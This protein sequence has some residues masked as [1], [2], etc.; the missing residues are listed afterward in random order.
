MSTSSC[1]ESNGERCEVGEFGVAN[2]GP[3]EDQRRRPTGVCVQANPSLSKHG[4]IRP[5]SNPS[6]RAI[7]LSQ[8]RSKHPAMFDATRFVVGSNRVVRLRARGLLRYKFPTN[9]Q[10]IPAEIPTLTHQRVVCVV[11]ASDGLQVHHLQV[12]RRIGGIRH[13]T[14]PGCLTPPRRET[15]RARY[16]GIQPALQRN[17]RLDIQRE[18]Q[19]RRGHGSVIAEKILTQCRPKGP[20]VRWTSD[21]ST[22]DTHQI[23]G[24]V[25][26]VARHPALGQC[27][28]GD[29]NKKGQWANERGRRRDVVVLLVVPST[30]LAPQT[31]QHASGFLLIASSASAVTI[32][33]SSYSPR[34]ATASLTSSSPPNH[35]FGTKLSGRVILVDQD[36]SKE[37]LAATWAH[38]QTLKTP[39]GNLEELVKNGWFRLQSGDMVAARSTR[40]NREPTKDV[41]VVWV[42][43]STLVPQ[44]LLD[45]YER[46]RDSFLGPVQSR[47]SGR[48][49]VS[50]DDDGNQTFKGGIAFERTPMAKGV[51]SGRAYTLGP[52]FERQT[53]NVAPVASLKASSEHY[54]AEELGEFKAEF[55][56]VGGFSLHC[57]PSS[58]LHSQALTAVA[59]H[60]IELGPDDVLDAMKAGAS[61]RNVP[62][63]GTDDNHYFGT[64]QLNVA[65][66]QRDLGFFGGSHYD[67]N[68][69]PGHYTS[70]M[71]HSILPSNYTPGFFFLHGLGVFLVM[72]ALLTIVFTG[73]RQHG[74]T[75]PLS[76]EGAKIQLNITAV[77]LTA[78]TYPPGA[79]MNGMGR[80]IIAAWPDG[81][82]RDVDISGADA[83]RHRTRGC[84]NRGEEGYWA[85]GL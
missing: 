78:V 76:P 74:G 40:G 6:E 11:C 79:L 39:K 32:P 37:G 35:P 9:R 65:A 56:K 50:E 16:A 77:R 67:R 60:T 17:R 27:V 41:P 18:K 2:P 83:L 53:K 85:K 80:L 20:C 13:S 5:A 71:N 48:P 62:A 33:T 55:I 24:E 34:G 3:S 73:L 29:G 8:Q 57:L 82:C 72:E 59:V 14:T 66:A 81:E 15:R 49:V 31:R 84:T 69:S 51:N 26:A 47:T 36:T 38:E 21:A 63:Y 42:V 52:S 23:R 4:F 7:D 10:E 61:V 54:D 68:D 22:T 64:T 45:E 70:M 19:R 25:K 43:G 46:A 30:E 44:T 58:Y 28:L 1:V 12:R 75:S